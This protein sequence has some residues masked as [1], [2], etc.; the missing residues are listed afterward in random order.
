MLPTKR[1]P[2]LE[3]FAL[4]IY[5][6]ELLAVEAQ[7]TAGSFFGTGTV[8][9]VQLGRCTVR[10]ASTDAIRDDRLAIIPPQLLQM[11]GTQPV[12][13]D[14][15]DLRLLADQLR[16]TAI[17]PRRTYLSRPES[18]HGSH[19]Q[20]IVANIDR[21]VIVVSV[22]APPLHP[23]LI[24]RYLVAVT[25]GEAKPLLCVNKIDLCKT[26]E[27]LDIELKCL[28]AYQGLDLEMVRVSTATGDG[29]D[30][31]REKLRGLTC[32]FVGHS[33]VGKSSFVKAL[34]P[35]LDLKVGEISDGNERG[36][37]TTTSSSLYECEDDLRLIDTPGIRSFG[38]WAIPRDELWLYFPDF[39]ESAMNCKFRD[40][41]HDRE[42]H[43][44]VRRASKQGGIHPA[45][46]DTY[47]RLLRSIP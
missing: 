31:L 24:D 23:R 16:V 2:S 47:I 28:E 43:C 37:H 38:L 1:T 10:L 29:L 32:A 5:R 35:S 33:G 19:E 8:V 34:A 7:A 18:G 45:R 46:Y 21:I 39:V 17:H 30:P 12:V 25:R 27:E 15:V 36:A 40:C 9:G 26:Q 20:M 3:E 22:V 42:P 44:G 41:R 11:T 6:E 14:E 4:R 13:G